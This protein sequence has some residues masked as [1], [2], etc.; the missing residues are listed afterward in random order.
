MSGRPSTRISMSQIAVSSV[1]AAGAAISTAAATQRSIG[2]FRPAKLCR[3]FLVRIL[4]S[5]RSAP[6]AE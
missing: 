1:S 6:F 4:V 5:L 3:L 2:D